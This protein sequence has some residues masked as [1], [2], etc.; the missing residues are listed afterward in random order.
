LQ[1]GGINRERRTWIRTSGRYPKADELTDVLV[2]GYLRGEPEILELGSDGTST[3]CHR[4]RFAVIGSGTAHAKIALHTLQV[5]SQL[6]QQPL[7]FDADTFL[8]VTLGAAQTAKMCNPPIHA[9]RLTPGGIQK[10]GPAG[11]PQ[12]QEQSA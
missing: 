5:R 4:H 1:L 2:A 12:E 8:I 6:Y 3:F 9:V 11:E 10:L 7:V